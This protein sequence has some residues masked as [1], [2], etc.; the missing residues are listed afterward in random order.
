[1][2][3]SGN[4]LS[5]QAHPFGWANCWKGPMQRGPRWSMLQGSHK[6][7]GDDAEHPSLLEAALTPA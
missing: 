6:E 1:M 3:F 7:G 5:L 4:I 2:V